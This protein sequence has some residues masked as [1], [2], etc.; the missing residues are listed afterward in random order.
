MIDKITLSGNGNKRIITFTNPQN[1][2]T[3][4]LQELYFNT[5][6]NDDLSVRTDNP[7]DEIAYFG[8]FRCAKSMSEQTAAFLLCNKYEKLRGLYVR[9]TY[10]QLK[11]S[12]IK[13]FKEDFEA[14]GSFV[15]YESKRI[16]KFRNGSELS[17]R[18]FE[19]DTNI[20]SNEYDFICVCQAEDIPYELFLQLF[21]RLSGNKL[22]KKLL[23][24]EGNPAPGAMKDRYKDSTEQWRKENK[25]FAITNAKTEANPWV[26]Q[27]YIDRI[28]RNYSPWWIARYLNSEWD[29]KSELVFD[30]WDDRNIIKPIDPKGIPTSYKR[31]NGMDWGWV[32]PTAIIWA[33]LD[34]DGNI[35]IY[36]EYYITKTI[37]ELVAKEGAR[38]GR[39]YTVADHAMKGLKMPD[40]QDT[41]RTIW[42]ELQRFGMVLIPCNKEELSN[43]IFTNT[44]MKHNK[45]KIAENCVNLLKE[46]KNWKWK[47]LKLGQDKDMPEE[48]IS[49]D[50]HGCDALNYLC[51]D[52]RE[53]VSLEPQKIDPD[54]T[55]AA[56][57]ARKEPRGREHLG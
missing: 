30:C 52:L 17:F 37:P 2:R 18:A 3:N 19:V 53:D 6:F 10:D 56:V 5:I 54:K 8:A 55:L 1:N 41:N 26:T 50:N 34:Y 7:Y 33:Y 40:G 9:T 4:E 38:H 21:G 42:T 51:E 31:R 15:Y 32:T 46:I 11:D 43:I 23:L 29:N 39:I 13:Q 20:L 47:Q 22:P 35:V 44:L 14:Y 36:D 25:I 24:A 57:T 16:A 45:I 28:K 49:K 27:D 48:P 12:V